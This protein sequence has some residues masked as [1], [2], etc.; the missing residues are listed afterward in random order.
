M[1]TI[2][3]FFNLFLV[4]LFSSGVFA[5]QYK[6]VKWIS[7]TNTSRWTWQPNLTLNQTKGLS[8]DAIEIYIEKPQQLV[9]GFGGCFNEKGWEALQLLDKS[10]QDSILSEM[11]QP[12]KGCRF[13]ICR[14]PIGASDYA[15]SWYSLND[16]PGDYEMKNFNIE[17]DK[18]CLIPYIKAAQKFNPSL[19]LWA[20]PWSPPA[21]LKT[22]NNYACKKSSKNDLR[23]CEGKKGVTLFKMDDASLKAYALYFS[24]FV[25]IY[26]EQGINIYAVHV[27]NEFNSCQIFPSCIWNTTDLSRFIG[28][29]L[30]PQFIRDGLS[31]EIWL[32]TIER[33]SVAKIDTI[34]SNPV[35][36][37]Y[38]K[39]MGFQWGGRGALAEVHHKYPKLK[40]MQTETE[41]GDGSN[42]WAAARHTFGLMKYYL[43]LGANSYMYWNMVLDQS[44]KST[45]G[46]KQN[47]MITVNSYTKKVTFTPEFY[48]M[49]HFSHFINP[50]AH[51]L[52]TSNLNRDV[53]A[54]QNPDGEIV[55]VAANNDKKAKNIAVKIKNMSFSVKLEAMS[56]NT[57]IIE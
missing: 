49:K 36:S 52:M 9:E 7:S 33:P 53:I 8:A 32:G 6:T 39:G 1:N 54:F 56:F 35:S 42:D 28:N 57:F 34:L 3:K 40:I 12:G 47:A 48:L 16:T 26:R 4:L 25:K 29:Y 44:G 5:Q 10:M 24:K 17:R 55:V 45:W 21:W 19:R 11:F 30:G 20:S 38:I 37:K 14:M 15:L 27:Q 22:N 2:N 41:C 31:T 18:R 46:W 13:N 23:C 51:N 50:G 43:S